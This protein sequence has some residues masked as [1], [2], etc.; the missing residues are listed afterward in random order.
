MRSY[1][2]RVDPDRAPRTLLLLPSPLLPAS[3]HDGLRDALGRRGLSASIA[4]GLLG[5]GQ[6]A[7]DLVPRWAS[8][9]GPGTVLVAHSNAGYL[10]PLVRAAGGRPGPIVFMDAA[11]LPAAGSCA[12]APAPFREWLGGLADAEGQLPP[13]TRWWPRSDLDEVLPEDLFAAVDAVCPRLP[14]DYFD[15][16]VTAPPGWV[17]EPNAYLAFGDTYGDERAFAER[18]GWPAAGLHGSHLAFVTEPDVVATTLVSLVE[19]LGA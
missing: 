3:V 5:T 8:L 2:R 19:R 1:D 17:D 14:L 13:W 16:V 9:V 4:P 10:A 18:Q 12:L 11:L 15:T 6:G 7:V